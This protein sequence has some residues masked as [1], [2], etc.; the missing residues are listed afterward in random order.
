MSAME[1]SEFF[2]IAG[3]KRVIPLPAS[4]RRRVRESARSKKVMPSS[5]VRRERRAYE[6]YPAGFGSLFVRMLELRNF[7]W[8]AAAQVMYVMSDVHVAASTIGAVGRGVR[9]LDSDLLHGFSSVLGISP[10]VMS[11]LVGEKNTGPKPKLPPEI[12]DAAELL[13]DVRQFTMEQIQ[14]A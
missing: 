4:E 1:I 9:E 2:L 13:W 8:S 5:L 12:G 10:S 3:L 7:G 11:R 6:R 14:G